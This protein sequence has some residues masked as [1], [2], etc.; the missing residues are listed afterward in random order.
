[1]SED[2]ARIFFVAKDINRVQLAACIADLGVARNEPAPMRLVRATV[3]QVRARAA[4]AA[5]RLLE[6]DFPVGLDMGTYLACKKEKSP[7]YAQ[8]P[9][10]AFLRTY[11][12]KDMGKCLC[13]YDAPAIRR[14]CGPVK[15][16]PRPST[17]STISPRHPM[18]PCRPARRGAAPASGRVD[19][20]CRFGTDDAT[21]GRPGQ[22]RRT[23]L[24]RST[25][26][27]RRRDRALGA[28]PLCRVLSQRA[29]R[30][31]PRRH[32]S[33][34]RHRVGHP[35]VHARPPLEL[36][37]LGATCSSSLRFD[38][39]ALVDARPGSSAASLPSA[40]RRTVSAG[41]SM[42]S[43]RATAASSGTW[44]RRLR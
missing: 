34:P 37:A 43:E 11:A 29:G 18:S 33:S 16:W 7:L 17:A 6:W 13:L 19:R 2:F 9:E 22:S 42:R 40:V 32:L 1:M 14:W 39:V 24:P 4:G 20:L 41:I 31:K 3:D 38:G 12:R 8:A 35:G 36:L 15:S 44:A 21:P 28:Q 26:P 30:G 23:V 10:V 25:V 5:S 27:R